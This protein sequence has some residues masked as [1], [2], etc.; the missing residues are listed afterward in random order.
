MSEAHRTGTGEMEEL[1]QSK[2][3][4]LESLEAKGIICKDCKHYDVCGEGT[5]LLCVGFEI[6]DESRV[7]LSGR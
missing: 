5:E 6:L 2:I 4:K 7:K 1:S 3:E